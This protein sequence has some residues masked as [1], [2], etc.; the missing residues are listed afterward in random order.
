VADGFEIA[1]AYVKISP[2]TDGFAEELESKLE[3]ATAGAEGKVKVGADDA[4]LDAVLDDA[5]A[6]LDEL[7]GK[8]ATASL[9]ADDADL[10][11]K[12][13]DATARLREIGE[14]K[15]TARLGMDKAAFDEAGDDATAK[16][17]EFDGKEA[18]AD[19]RLN[20][21]DWDAEIA[22]A[23]A[24]LDALK[25]KAGSIRLGGA[26]GSGGSGG[27]SEGGEGSLLAAVG[28]AGGGLLP[29]AGGMLSGLGLLG[30]TG[31]LAF[32]GIAKALSAAHQS[33]E[34]VG[35]TGAQVASTNFSNQVQVQQ[36]QQ[37]VTQAKQ[38]QAQDTITSNDQIQSGE[39]NLAE[40]Q[41]NTAASQVQ[42]LQ[43][44]TQAQQQ[45]QQSTYGLSEA[46]YNLG[47]AYVQAREQIT[48]LND[49]LADSK[50]SVSAASL[51]VQQAQY[52]ETLV[53]QSAY[54][55]DLDRQSATLAVAQ[56]KQQLQD[57]TDS[58][59][60][61]QTAANL[62]NSQGVD[63]S[64]TV[65]QAKQAQKAAQDQLTDANAS[66][67]AAQTALTNTELN[68]AQQVKQ[69]QMQASE[70]QE[71]AAYQQK[72]DAQSVA[73]AE[74]N[75]T[76]TIREQQLQ[77]AATESTAN[78]A[79]N[80]FA[81]YMAKL[82]PAGRGFVNQ[83]L[84]MGGAFKGLEADAQN[85]TLPGFTIFLQGVSH[86][87]PEISSGVTKMGGAVSGAFARMGQ[88]M[89][90]PQAVTVF[91]GL[92]SNGMEFANTVLPSIGRA[93]GAIFDLGSSK[94]AATGLSQLLKGVFDGVAGFA[95]GLKPYIPDFNDLFEAI[96][97]IAKALGPAF[98][99]DIGG[100]AKLLDPLAKFLNS[101]TGQPFVDTI[102]KILAGLLTM[103]GLAKLLP[104]DL[105]KAF[106]SVK[107]LMSLPKLV[108]EKWETLTGIPGKIGGAW[109]K[110][111]GDGA[112]VPGMIGNLGNTLTSLGGKMSTVVGSIKDWGIWSKIAAGTTKLWEGAQWAF[113]AAMDANPIGIIVIALAGLALGIYEA[114]Q[115]FTWFRDGV[116]DAFAVVEAG[117]LWLWHNVLD[118]VWH[119]IE[120]GAEW[121]Y[122]NGI[123]RYFDLVQ[124]E[125]KIIET[126]ALWLW[127][128]VFDPVWHG[129]EQ[130][131]SAFVNA[132]G[133]AWGKLEGVF[134]APVNFLIQ[135]VY[136]K[137][138]AGLWNDVVGA[139]GLG[140]LKLPVIP[141]LAHGGIVPGTDHGRDEVLIA[142]RP[143]EGVL[144][145]GA[146]RAI[147]GRGAIN[148]LNSAHG[149][150]GTGAAGHY[151]LGGIIS[152]AVDTAKMT[153][154]ALTGNTTAFTN[155]AAGI[156][157]TSAAGEL[158]QVMLAIPKTLVGDLAKALA[159]AVG[160]GGGTVKPSGTVASWFAA[161][162]KAAG[163]PASWIP[164]EETI[165]QHESSD[166]P[167]AINTTDSNAAAGDP[168][169]GIMQLIGTTFAQYH[170]PGTSMNIYDPVANIAAGSRYIGA[171]YGTP[172]NVPGIMSIA[173]GGKYVG[174]DSGGPLPPGMTAAVNMTGQTEEVLTPAE[175]AAWV[176]IVKQMTSGGGTTGGTGAAPTMIN[177]WYGPQMPSQETLA[178]MDRH[179]SLLLGG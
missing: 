169:R 134:K 1:V 117:A 91:N 176:A 29:G 40:V 110:V 124:D 48:Q 53:N 163:V 9:R 164:D 76:N 113:D 73:V 137:G 74:R 154:A 3:E 125:F 132:F 72:M 57:A 28:L 63:G 96:G 114:Y 26:G 172:A 77:W 129:I 122:T 103:K 79:A 120:Q 101:K 118:P 140:S 27:G 20:K 12:A 2:D 61:S 166:D 173:S 150:G 123:K 71:Q 67:S 19:L 58:E 5:K 158:G 159:S 168:S 13:D 90:T 170:V 92:I 46:N 22:E 64:Q 116:K 84:S 165:G 25:A 18:T 133:T 65:I 106:S 62:A 98:A 24:Q 131:A 81:K 135:T 80:Q 30:A 144:V 78:S 85:A 104:G 52:Q 97:K 115:H 146:V 82:T 88:E 68:N 161:G 128:N 89:K 38:Q 83:I 6:K 157:G 34:N 136:D 111:F 156:I 139:V 175:R 56:A 126:A 14:T 174:Y 47:Q 50:L 102:A 99:K 33:S 75:L 7:D 143:E 41:R 55:T 127:H 8:G 4:E 86:L 17:D 69:A 130:G 45:V 152:S 153:A 11:A 151:S 70:A 93:F 59:A 95:K 44:V 177:N 142:A 15:A 94:G 121:L 147:G 16:L 39:M 31:G 49:Q 149:G 35:L 10:S 171:R 51:A 105:G 178:E 141:A 160:G 119:G 108:G 43:S 138:I 179:Y 148:A 100:I 60:D 36:A 54:S 42:A 109:T 66:Y 87:A 162:T 107:G 145:P 23:D 21:A 167:N 155:A 37:S 112:E 32:G